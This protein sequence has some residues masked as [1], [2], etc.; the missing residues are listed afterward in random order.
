MGGRERGPLTEA[1]FYTL[2]VL[3]R[4]D[5][6]GT[7]IAQAVA[8]RTAGRVRLGPGTLYTL[9]GKFLEERYIRETETGDAGR[10][11]TYH[12]TEAGR[13]AYLAELQRLKQCVLDAEEE[14]P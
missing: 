1:M 10:R 8:E 11:R 7:E 9:L 6:C 14:L 5:V 3:A 13:A 2:M 4:R 12:L